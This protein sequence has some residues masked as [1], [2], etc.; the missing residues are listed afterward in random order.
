MERF[1]MIVNSEKD[2]DNKTAEMI[3]NYIEEKGKTCFLLDSMKEDGYNEHGNYTNAERI[4]KDTQCAIVLGGDGTLLHAAKDLLHLDLPI[5]GV[6]LGTV[7]YLAELE[8][9]NVF[10]ALDKLFLDE[11]RIEKRLMLYGELHRGGRVEFCS[12]SLN[13]I[14]ISRSGECRL[15]VLHLYIN[16]LLIDT[17]VADGL[18]VSTP[19]GSTGYNLSAGGPVMKPG[20]DAIVVTSVCPHSLNKRSFVIS[21][22]DKI[23]LEI[24]QR[25][26]KKPDEAMLFFDGCDQIPVESGDSIQIQRAVECTKMIKVTKN[27]Y[28]DILKSKLGGERM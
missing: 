2:L 8:P 1:C 15:V 13:D 14:V 23:R 17:Y 3:L 27:S 18:I 28:F 24:G 7:G 20:I 6:N 9:Q 11:C 25:K 16:D 4:P 19:T 5:L 22:E 10:Q 12:H 21:A 26:E